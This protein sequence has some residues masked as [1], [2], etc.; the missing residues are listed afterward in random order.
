MACALT[1]C[2]ANCTWPMR[3]YVRYSPGDVELWVEH[4]L[5]EGRPAGSAGSAAPG[6]GGSIA[7]LGRMGA[8]ASKRGPGSGTGPGSIGGSMFEEPRDGR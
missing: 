5:F 8:G 4:D 1:I 2:S 7:G 3:R 6:S